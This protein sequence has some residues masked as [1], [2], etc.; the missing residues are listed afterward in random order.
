MTQPVAEFLANNVFCII[1]GDGCAVRGWGRR[2]TA[3]EFGEWVRKLPSLMGQG[4]GLGLAGLTVRRPSALHERRG[5]R[6]ASEMWLDEDAV[7]GDEEEVEVMLP[8]EDRPEEGRPPSTFQWSE[9]LMAS[10]S[11]LVKPPS[12]VREEEA[13]EE[14]VGQ[15]QP[16]SWTIPEEQEQQAESAAA[17]SSSDTPDHLAQSARS[18]S[19]KRRGKR[20]AR[21][22]DKSQP[23]PDHTAASSAVQS[24]LLTATNLDE[25]ASNVETF[26]NE[27]SGQLKNHHG[28][29][30]SLA[31]GKSRMSAA[32][33]ALA[34]M[35]PP[36]SMPPPVPPTPDAS[37]AGFKELGKRLSLQQQAPLPP[38]E[39][40]GK[41]SQASLTKNLASGIGFPEMSM[42]PT[43]FSV[44][45]PVPQMR[46]MEK[47]STLR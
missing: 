47:V 17:A 20:G 12:P 33:R 43:G 32:E 39:P 21:R 30:T 26:A 38:K 14:P 11:T 3:R 8:L 5:S 24:P 40:V 18:P 6:L 45:M 1:D 4:A 9:V 31:S 34:R 46:K 28:S 36:P 22:K 19:A 35:P 16:Q 10:N 27:I 7:A 37:V 13:E 44:P 41:N 42:T 15:T 25:L 2:C 29:R 23:P